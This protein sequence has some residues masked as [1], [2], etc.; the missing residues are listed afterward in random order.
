M[1]Q[2]FCPTCKFYYVQEDELYNVE[3]E[4]TESKYYEI[5]KICPDCLMNMV[6]KMVYGKVHKFNK[7][8]DKG[9]INL[10]EKAA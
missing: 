6:E 4:N 1:T 3:T 5:N 8:Y 9:K 10:A 7:R 2:Y